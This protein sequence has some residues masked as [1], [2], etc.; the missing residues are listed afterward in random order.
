MTKLE[1]NSDLLYPKGRE[2]LDLANVQAVIEDDLKLNIRDLSP[3]DPKD[4]GDHSE[5]YSGLLGDQKVFIK[6]GASAHLLHFQVEMIAQELLR[7]NGIP[8]PQTLAFREVAKYIE[9]SIVVQT[10]AEGIALNRL[11][12][13]QRSSKVLQMAGQTLRKIHDITLSGFGKL[14]LHD[15]ELEGSSP[16]V[17]DYVE[18]YKPDLMYLTEHGFL[19][20]PECG[21]IER[22]FGEISETEVPRASFLH[23][24]FHGAHIFTDG[25]RITSI[26]DLA[27]ASAGDPRHDIAVAH[28]YLSPTDRAYFDQG[29]G[30]LALDPLVSMYHLLVAARKVEYRS[31][32]NFTDRI[33]NAV[34]ILKSSLQDILK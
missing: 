14:K 20:T 33:P 34:K 15:G 32:K 27:G 5:V 19:E 2:F 30:D 16:S 3:L 12:P 23:D 26:I 29:Y 11:T 4:L 7:Q 21:V 25:E 18:H 13:E 17:K 28:F 24:D 6:I 8:T 10:A 9:R 31:K 22:I 1:R